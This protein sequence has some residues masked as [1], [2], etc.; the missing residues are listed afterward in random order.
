MITRKTNVKAFANAP[1]DNTTAPGAPAA[2]T[3][4]KAPERKILGINTSLTMPVRSS[5]RGSK[6]KYPFDSVEVGKSIGVIGGNAASMASTISGANRRFMEDKKD[7]DGNVVRKFIDVKGA[8]GSVT[9]TDAGPERVSTRHFFAVDVDP[10]SDPE[11]A[12]VRIWRDK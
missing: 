9:K 3:P 1:K 2:G 11:G 10:K 5:N 6:S 4:A 8:D 12:T 7:A